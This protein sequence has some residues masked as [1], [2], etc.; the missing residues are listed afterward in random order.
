[1]RETGSVLRGHQ[2]ACHAVG[3]SPSVRT[4]QRDPY[5]V[6]NYLHMRQRKLA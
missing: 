4:A 5:G 2:V 1:M 6:T 3:I